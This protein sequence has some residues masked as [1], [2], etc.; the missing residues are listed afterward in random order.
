[1]WVYSAQDWGALKK[2]TQVC[3]TAVEYSVRRLGYI[4]LMAE[5][6]S[7]E[8][9]TQR[10]LKKETQVCST[11]NFREHSGRS[12]RNTVSGLTGSIMSTNVHSMLC[13]GPLCGFRVRLPAQAHRW[14]SIRPQAQVTCTVGK[15]TKERP[16][17]CGHISS[18]QFRKFQFLGILPALCSGGPP[19]SA[20][21]DHTCC[22]KV[23][24][25]WPCLSQVP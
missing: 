10:A 14:V 17:G 9:C 8:M 6:L 18:H 21:G 2:E 5:E 12:Y 15:G 11:Q 23:N 1:M 19:G 25:G 22:Q 7:E 24:P 20:Q 13:Q 16:F 4:V 3:S